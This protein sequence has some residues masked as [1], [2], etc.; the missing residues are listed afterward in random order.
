MLA[1]NA[2]G[3]EKLKPLVIGFSIS[4]LK[5]LDQIFQIQNHQV[6]LLVDNA[7]SHFHDQSNI[8]NSYKLD[9]SNSDSNKISDNDLAFK[10]PTNKT[11][12]L[13]LVLHEEIEVTINNLNNS[14]I[15]TENK[16]EDSKI[17]KIVLDK[18]NQHKNGDSDDSDEEEPE[19]LILESLMSLN[20]FVYFFEQQTD[21]DFKAK[22]LKIFQKYLTL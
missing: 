15:I 18:E 13:L 14:C 3:N 8:N 4:T 1:C 19:I 7:A 21:T 20:K 5:D 16:L 6:L 9:K 17:V 11:E 2:T 12:I 10:M 22:D